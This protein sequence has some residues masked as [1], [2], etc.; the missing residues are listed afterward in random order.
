MSHPPK[1]ARPEMPISNHNVF[2]LAAIGFLAYYVVGMW[3]EILGHG[4]ALYL[5]GAR[6]F[7][8]T[9]TSMGSTDLLLP[10]STTAS[11][12]VDAA[13]SLST[14]LLGI[15]LYPLVYSTFR[16]RANPVLRLF[17]W[18]VAAIGIF[19]GFSY[20]AFSG[21]A[22][23]GDWK[24]VIEQW[25]HQGLLRAVE[26]VLR[27]SHMHLGSEVLREVVWRV[28]GK[29]NSIVT[30]S[31]FLWNNRFLLS[32]ASSSSCCILLRDFS[33]S[34]KSYWSGHFSVHRSDRA[35]IQYWN[36]RERHNSLL[37]R[38][39]G[40]GSNC[41]G[42][43]RSNCARCALH[44]SCHRSSFVYGINHDCWHRAI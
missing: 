25:P 7:M 27:S 28:L 24:G 4:L 32:R 23:V 1:A 36:Q 18:L 6:H 42:S 9:S 29:L 15:A 38:C 13:G 26:V 14:I 19:H 34:S 37:C 39:I 21:V 11:R 33:N 30:S 2:T 44:F 41:F 43:S 17:L 16:D 40:C 3:H 22:N 31:V 8:L 10:S 12:V 5:Y 20:I 35:Q